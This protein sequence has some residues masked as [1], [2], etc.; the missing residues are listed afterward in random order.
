M[1]AISRKTFFFECST[2][3]EVGINVTRTALCVTGGTSKSAHQ[4]SLSTT[5]SNEACKLGINPCKLAKWRRRQEKM[6]KWAENSPEV[7]II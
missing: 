7:I 2:L 1:I 4:M 5:D 3:W 6:R